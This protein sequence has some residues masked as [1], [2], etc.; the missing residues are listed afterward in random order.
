MPSPKSLP[1]EMLSLVPAAQR[2]RILGERRRGQQ[3]QQQA[4]GEQK[5][6]QSFF[7]GSPPH[8]PGVPSV[9]QTFYNRIIGVKT[10]NCQALFAKK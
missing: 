3:H 10:E 8:L 7:H 5:T 6:Q 4:A 2:R 9:I 1:V